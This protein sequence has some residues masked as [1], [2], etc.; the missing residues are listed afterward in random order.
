MK[1]TVIKIVAT[2]VILTGAIG[3]VAL[4]DPGTGGREEA[5]AVVKK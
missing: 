1:K 4:N 5:T 3:A 2:V